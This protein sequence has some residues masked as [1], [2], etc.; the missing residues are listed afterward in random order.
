MAAAPTT[1]A[2][3]LVNFLAIAIGA[4]AIEAKG[5]YEAAVDFCFIRSV[6]VPA[7]GMIFEAPQLYGNDSQRHNFNIRIPK[8]DAQQIKLLSSM[9]TNQLLSI[10]ASV[11]ASSYDNRVSFKYKCITFE[12]V[13]KK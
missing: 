13:N 11:S 6:F 4:N 10:S 7:V 5:D 1:N 9:P 12:L 3:D 8:S 2:P